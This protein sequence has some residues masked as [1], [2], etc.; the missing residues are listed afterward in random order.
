MNG[1]EQFIGREKELAFL[2]EQYRKRN[3]SFVVI[4]G[5]RRVGKTALISRFISGKPTLY[6]LATE[7][8]EAQNRSGFRCMAAEF[9]GNELLGQSQT[10]G[11]FLIFKTLMEEKKGKPLII[12]IDEFQY[13]AG[14]NPAF[15]S[16]Y[17][18]NLGHV[19]VGRQDHAYPLR[20][21]RFND[22][23]R[24]SFL[25]KSPVWQAHRTDKAGTNSFFPIWKILFR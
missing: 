4:Y 19:S 25:R 22:G 2:E 14:V 15:P 23:K 8:N 17:A 20:F 24:R 3:A 16:I 12:A 10:A 13:L 5:R 1:A 11:W 18:K 21:F 6:F 9:T 7:E